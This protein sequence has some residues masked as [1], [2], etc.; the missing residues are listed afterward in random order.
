MM[1]FIDFV[2]YIRMSAVSLIL[3]YSQ[4]VQMSK[5]DGSDSNKLCMQQSIM[6]LSQAEAKWHEA[7]SYV[8]RVSTLSKLKASLTGENLFS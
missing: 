1:F 2:R 3:I 4:L 8:V 5:I 7:T 6:W